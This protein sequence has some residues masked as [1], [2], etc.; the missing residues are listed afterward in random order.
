LTTAVVC[1]WLFQGKAWTP[2]DHPK[3]RREKANLL[4]RLEVRG[5]DVTTQ[6]DEVSLVRSYIYNMGIIWFWRNV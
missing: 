2:R 6:M 5:A 1:S 4:V 3:G